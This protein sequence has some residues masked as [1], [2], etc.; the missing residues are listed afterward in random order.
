MSFYNPCCVPQF[1]PCNFG[2]VGQV[3]ATGATGPASTTPDPIL[4]TTLQFNDVATTSSG[5]MAAQDI[6][7]LNPAILGF[8]G[9]NMPATINFNNPFIGNANI[10]VLPRAGSIVGITGTLT[11]PNAA[12]SSVPNVATIYRVSIY[13]SSAPLTY[14]AF[15]LQRTSVYNSI[16]SPIV[17]GSST[18]VFDAG[19]AL[20]PFPQGT[21]LALVVS[22]IAPGA[23]TA[24]SGT[25]LDGS[26][27]LLYL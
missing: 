14:G 18:Y 10:V 12:P 6:V 26:F 9:T 2:P 23:S 7:G 27:S 21:F 25:S 5:T 3:G 20:G 24:L 16:A 11:V 15:A 1:T 22:A 4:I 17:I 19:F 13:T 8:S